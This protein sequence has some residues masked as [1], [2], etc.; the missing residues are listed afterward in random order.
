MGEMAVDPLMGVMLIAVDP[1]KIFIFSLAQIPLLLGD[2]PILVID[3][4]IFMLVKLALKPLYIMGSIL[5]Y[6]YISPIFERLEALKNQGVCQESR[7]SGL[8]GAGAGHWS[9]EEM[10]LSEDVAYQ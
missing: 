5:T 4:H 6:I 3:V 9:R 2:F 1:W 7:A 8:C 10:G